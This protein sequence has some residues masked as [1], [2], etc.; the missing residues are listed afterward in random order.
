MTIDDLQEQE[1]DAKVDS[2]IVAIR[3]EQQEN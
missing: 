1:A 2:A 3:H